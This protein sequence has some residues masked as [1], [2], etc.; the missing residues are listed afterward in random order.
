MSQYSSLQLDSF[1]NYVNHLYLIDRHCEKCS[2]KIALK[3]G[4]IKLYLLFT[5]LFGRVCNF[6]TTFTKLRV[7]ET[8]GNY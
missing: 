4:Q 7:N 3:W 5:L 2:V 6:K 1:S 8:I